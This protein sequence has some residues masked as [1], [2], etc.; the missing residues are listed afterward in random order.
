MFVC[1]ASALIPVVP[2]FIFGG[3]AA[4]ILLVLTVAVLSLLSFLMYRKL[5]ALRLTTL[6]ED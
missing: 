3:I 6:A 5:C 1:F 2:I 4:H